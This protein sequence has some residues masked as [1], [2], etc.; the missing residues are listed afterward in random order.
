VLASDIGRNIDFIAAEI[1]ASSISLCPL[2]SMTFALITK[3]FLSIV[4]FIIVIPSNPFL[5]DF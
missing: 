2:E 5:I 1:E 4:T 3:P